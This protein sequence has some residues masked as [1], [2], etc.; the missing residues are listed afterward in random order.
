MPRACQSSKSA[1]PSRGPAASNHRHAPASAP[2]RPEPPSAVR[3]CPRYRPAARADTG[4]Q[5]A[6]SARANSAPPCRPRSR[7]SA[8]RRWPHAPGSASRRIARPF[9][10]H[11]ARR[12]AHCRRAG[13]RRSARPG[14]Y[15]PDPRAVQPLQLG[16]G[17]IGQQPGDRRGGAIGRIGRA[18]CRARDMPGIAPR[19]GLGN[20]SSDISVAPGPGQNFGQQHRHGGQ[21]FRLHRRE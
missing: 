15:S 19:Q 5:C 10:R 16:F 21:R 7:R 2:C 9:G 8:R 17:V 12:A 3:S 6:A 4:R 20:P 11:R 13:R 18:R 1:G 14:F